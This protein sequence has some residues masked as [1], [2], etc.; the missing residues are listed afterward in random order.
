MTFLNS[1]GHAPS[2]APSHVPWHN[3]DILPMTQLRRPVLSPT[4]AI[5]PIASHSPHPLSQPPITATAS[6]TGT[7]S[8]SPAA[9]AQNLEA[10]PTQQS[11]SPAIPPQV[12]QSFRRRRSS[13]PPAAGSAAA[14]HSWMQGATGTLASGHE[15]FS[16]NAGWPSANGL[17]PLTGNWE[18]LL[19]FESDYGKSPSSGV[20]M[21]RS[22]SQNAKVETEAKAP[23]APSP[24]YNTPLKTSNASQQHTMERTAS[25]NDQTWRTILNQTLDVEGVGNVAVA[26]ILTEVWKRGGPAAVSSARDRDRG[27]V[28]ICV[29]DCVQLVVQYP[30]V[31][32]A[33][34]R[35]RDLGT[36]SPTVCPVR[37]VLASAVQRCN[38]PT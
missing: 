12:R 32:I 20:G 25:G 5:S 30:R 6:A 28:L 33:L 8:K 2:S 34:T 9:T 35:S 36:N 14:A 10:S 15:P 3:T 1:S 37:V 17:T 38:P 26:R 31:S 18:S 23:A 22:P 21:E 11:P 27:R 19:N 29:G 24:R 4:R 7:L 16:S 13:F